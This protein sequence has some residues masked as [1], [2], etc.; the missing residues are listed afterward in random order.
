MKILNNMNTNW[1]FYTEL[2]FDNTSISCYNIDT[3]DFYGS[4]VNFEYKIDNFE[5]VLKHAEKYLYS[6]EE[7][8]SI[9]NRLFAESGG[10]GKW[11]MLD[12]KSNNSKV[13]NWNLKYIRVIRTSLGFILCNLQNEAIE[14]NLIDLPVDQEYLNKY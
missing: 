12:L 14:K 9:L 8:I 3:R 11:R 4:E 10:K 13:L 5:Y 6:K 7:V 1:K 2:N